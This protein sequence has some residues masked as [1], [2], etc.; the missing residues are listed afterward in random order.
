M[1]DFP[2]R[3]KRRLRR[4]LAGDLAALGEGPEPLGEADLIELQALFARPKFFISGHARSGT[5]LLARLTRLHP[6]VHCN[7]QGHFF[8]RRGPLPYLTAP[9]LKAWFGAA[10]N[11]WTVEG[12]NPALLARVLCDFLMEH[13]AAALDKGIVGD[14]TP[15]EDGPAAMEWMHALYPDARLVY[16][17]RDGRDVLVS[18]RVQAFIDHPEYLDRHDLAIRRSLQA[19]GNAYLAA[20]RSIFTPRALEDMSRKWARD[21]AECHRA[22]KM[23]YG[24]RYYSLRYED[25]LADPGG[26]MHSVWSHL[27]APAPEAGVLR[28]VEAELNRNPASEW[29]AQAA[30][31]LVGELPRG[32]PGGWRQV[33]NPRDQETIERVAGETLMAWG[34]L[35]EER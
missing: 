13:Q 19:Q 15:H 11:R 16:I 5:T 8:S 33:L 17:V 32:T 2:A 14:K 10:S 30:P 21:V 4:A 28:R 12:E 25:L 31:D 1:A 26:N 22:G 29:H 27:G 18:K 35:E 9:G 3:L 7:W 6:E 20:G 34:Y 23:L 24:D